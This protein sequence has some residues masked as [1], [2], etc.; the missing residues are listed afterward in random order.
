M[1]APMRYTASSASVK[2]TRFRNSSTRK[3]FA[4]A[5]RKRFMP[6]LV[7][8]VSP[9]KLSQN[10][11][12]AASLDNFILGG[13]AESVSVNSELILEIAIAQNLYLLHGTNK[14]VRAK[15]I[16]R[17]CF[18]SRKSVQVLQIDDGKRFSKRAA[19]ATLWNAAVQRHLASFKSHAA[20]IAAA[21]LQAIITGTGGSAQL[22]AHTK[23]DAYF[24]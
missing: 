22:S 11:E 20:A 24:A 7:S 17:D 16:R 4:S 15:Q 21:G 19:K 6:A 3:R 8:T 5:C 10:I 1:C 18:S 9:E 14:S 2:R 12:R 13:G 23:A